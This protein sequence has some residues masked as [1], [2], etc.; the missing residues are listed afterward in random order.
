VSGLA[1][2]IE[3]RSGAGLNG[4]E[5]NTTGEP[6]RHATDQATAADGN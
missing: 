2:A 4:Y 6:R 1:R 3:S 5:S